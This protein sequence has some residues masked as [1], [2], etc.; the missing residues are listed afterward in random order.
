MQ[1][2]ISILYQ[3][4]GEF[5]KVVDMTIFPPLDLLQILNYIMYMY[6]CI[7]TKL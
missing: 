2:T 5:M 7:M 1:N 6:M 3:L 4:V